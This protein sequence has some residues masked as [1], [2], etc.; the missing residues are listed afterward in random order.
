VRELRNVIERALLLTDGAV[1]SAADL[2]FDYDSHG[3]DA[4]DT[5]A[6]AERIHVQ[7]VVREENGDIDRA[8]LRLGVARSTLYQKLK[9]YAEAA[10]PASQTEV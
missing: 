9:K 10:D 2:R 8:A 6:A 5:I 1:I 3:G 7:R 4:A